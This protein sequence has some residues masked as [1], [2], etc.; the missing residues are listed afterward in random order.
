MQYLLYMLLFM[1]CV[2]AN[3]NIMQRLLHDE[4]TKA[5]MCFY[6]WLLANNAK[7]A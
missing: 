3:L 2:F 4:I 5:Y 6:V 1:L 7:H